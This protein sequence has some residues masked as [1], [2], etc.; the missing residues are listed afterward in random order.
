MLRPLFFSAILVAISGCGA[1]E[2]KQLDAALLEAQFRAR[3]LSDPGLARFLKE[4][5][6][7]G[8]S[9]APETPWNLH[10]LTLA[11][12]YFHPDLEVSR[13]RLEKIYAGETT[14]GAW[15]NPVVSAGLDYNFD[16]PRGTSPWTAIADLSLPID[17]GGRRQHRIS[18][19]QYLSAAVW[20]ELEETAWRTRS[21]LRRSLVEHLLASSRLEA[22]RS[23]EGARRELVTLFDQRLEAG[24]ASA[25]ETGAARIDLARVA[26]SR[27]AAEARLAGTLAGLAA[28][29]GVPAA[30]LRA[31]RLGWP[32]IERLPAEESL[33]LPAVQRAG[34]LNRFDILKLLS[35][36][37]AAD[38]SL[39][40]EMAKRFPEISLGPGY[41]FE[42]GENKFT[43]GLSMTLP[44]FNRNGG[45]IA[46]AA[47]QRKEAA[48]RFL[49]LQARAINDLEAALSSYRSALQELAESARL[50]ALAGT[51]EKNVRRGLELGQNDRLEVAE[52]SAQSAMARRAWTEALLKSQLALGALEDE[53]QQPL[54]P[55]AILPPVTSTN[56]RDLTRKT[57]P[58][59]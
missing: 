18:R 7:A 11:A 25:T 45:P 41:T 53:L 39:R 54:D 46:E 31:V 12:F 40:L 43:F 34:L 23:E 27:L 20:R 33:A 38:A 17:I 4:N 48:A 3:S 58:H 9:A 37:Q 24:A 44:I 26:M 10:S 13:A 6:P 19:A 5:L 8:V 29:I 50:A 35:E 51:L 15:P 55:S 16:I 1:Q 30:A 56:P 22:L 2:V 59:E 42:E 21:R 57:S 28:A 47:A 49:A 36:Y 32:E 52:S 14:A